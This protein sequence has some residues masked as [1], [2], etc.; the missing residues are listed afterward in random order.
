MTL[1]DGFFIIDKPQGITS[2]GVIAR[3]RKIFNVR[4]IGHAGT[5]DPLATGILVV[6]VGKATKQLK[7]YVGLDKEYEAEMKFGWVSDTD[8]S[9]GK[10]VERECKVFSIEQLEKVLMSFVGDIEQIP[11]QFSA[12][13]VAGQR[14]YK[15][16]RKGQKVELKPRKVHIYTLELLDFSWPFARIRVSCSTGTYI[17]ALIRDIGSHIGCGAVMTA[18]RRTKVGEYTLDQAVSLDKVD[19]GFIYSVI[20]I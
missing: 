7:N 4:K 11:P 5:L 15:L 13:K 10:L 16:A 14:A 12:L 18:L 19:N 20:D 6:A 2:F 8:D 9:T 17:R 1:Q 3:L